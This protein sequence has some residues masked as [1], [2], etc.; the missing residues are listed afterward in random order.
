MRYIK[1]GKTVSAAEHVPQYFRLS[2]AERL[3]KENENDTSVIVRPMTE[4]DVKAISAI[5]SRTFSMPWHEDDFREMINAEHAHYY[6]A[7]V[8]DKLV[9]AA[10]MQSVAGDGSINNILVDIP[11]RRRGIGRRLLMQMLA[12][13]ASEVEIF[14]LEVRESNTAAIALYESMGFS[15]TAKR[16]DFYEKPREDALIYTRRGDLC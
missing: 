12:D 1:E 8:D 15:L 2:Q 7:E 14:S 5:E 6:V 13:Q 9:G 11:F 3:K 10:G 4:A 16:P